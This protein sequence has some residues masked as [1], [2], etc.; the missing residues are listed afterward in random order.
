VGSSVT[1]IAIGATISIFPF[2]DRLGSTTDV[3]VTDTVVPEGMAAG[4]VYVTLP[5]ASL[6]PKDP[7]APGLPHVTDQVT[8]P[9]PLA[10]WPYTAVAD[11]VTCALTANELGGGEPNTTLVGSAG[12]GEPPPSPEPPQPASRA[13]R[14]QCNKIRFF[15]C[16]F[17]VLCATVL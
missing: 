2:A 4:A 17:H 7:Q 13:P 12:A 1:S 11:S 14:A 10:N 9:L 6:G 5:A 16:R 15:M 8:A 3:A